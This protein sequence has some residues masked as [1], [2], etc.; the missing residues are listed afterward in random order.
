MERRE[1]E[2]VLKR[3][4]WE[5]AVFKERVCPDGLGVEKD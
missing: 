4:T 5:F 3:R 2:W 1:R